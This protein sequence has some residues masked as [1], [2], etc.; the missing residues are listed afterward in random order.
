MWSRVVG[1]AGRAALELDA[2]RSASMQVATSASKAE[3]ALSSDDAN[4][5]P[6]AAPIKAFT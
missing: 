2:A 6:R 5:K 3:E 4:G 1:E